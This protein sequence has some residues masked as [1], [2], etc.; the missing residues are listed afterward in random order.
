MRPKKATQR[1][2][3]VLWNILVDKQ[4]I[5]NKTV[6]EIVV[7][8]KTIQPEL[9]KMYK[10]YNNRTYP[11]SRSGSEKNKYIN[12]KNVKANLTYISDRWKCAFRIKWVLDLINNKEIK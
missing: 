10:V 2:N 8:L 3:N 12:D 7:L 9:E 4:E 11:D 5:Q 6:P 1:I